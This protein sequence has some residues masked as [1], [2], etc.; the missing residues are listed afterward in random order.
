MKPDNPSGG[1]KMVPWSIVLDRKALSHGVLRLSDFLICPVCREKRIPDEWAS[2]H[3][4]GMCEECSYAQ[5]RENPYRGSAVD[6]RAFF[7]RLGLSKVFPGSHRPR[8]PA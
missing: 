2:I 4:S 1:H 7:Q 3:S 6:R 5:R 8:I